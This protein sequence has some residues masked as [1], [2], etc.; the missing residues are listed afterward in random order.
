MQSKR[1]VRDEERAIAELARLQRGVVAREQLIA[2]GLGAGAIKHRLRQGRLQ[3]LHRGVYAVGHSNLARQARWLA[4]TLAYAPD[5]VLSYRAG[6]AHWQ[7]IRDMGWCEVTVP[8]KRRRRPG[9]ELHLARLAPD[10]ITVLDGVPVTTAPRT[11][12]DLAAVLS[13][14]QLERAINE[15]EVRQLWDE[16]SLEH[17]LRRYP[18]RAGNATVRAALHGRQQGSTITRSELEDMF[19]ALVDEANL[20]RPQI[21]ALVESFEVDAVW[22]AARVVI[23]LDGRRTHGT[24]AAFEADRER[25]RRLAAAGWR[26]VRVTYRQMTRTPVALID[27]LRRLLGSKGRTLAA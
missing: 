4:A 10:E 5:G 27:D 2:L 22:R 12:F 13:G 1:S 25:D 9:I 8:A 24:A 21:N 7:L 17:L 6:G 23:E 11:L 3:R 14:R 19:I 16:L 20:P 26:P 15:A 18:R